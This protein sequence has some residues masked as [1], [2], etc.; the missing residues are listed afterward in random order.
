MLLV[1]ESSYKVYL[2]LE[3]N[4]IYVQ[5]EGAL[6]VRIECVTKEKSRII[7]TLNLTFSYMFAD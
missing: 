3:S 4:L 2:Q 7:D 1:S 5:C 6:A